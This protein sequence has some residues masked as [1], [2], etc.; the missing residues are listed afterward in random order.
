MNMQW[1]SRT[2]PLAALAAVAI[3]AAAMG[4]TPPADQQAASA[5]PVAAP[6]AATPAAD[7]TPGPDTGRKSAQ[8]EIIVTGS[9][10]RRKDL[11]TP[12]PV[13]VISRDQ[14]TSSGV[15]SI[16]A[17]LQQLP[18]QG[19]AL[20]TNVNNGG[21]GETQINLRNLGS[22][23]TLVLVDGKRFVNGGVG[24]GTAVDL[25]SIP[26]AAVE[27]IEILKDGGSAVY[28]SD[29]IAGVVNIITR[30][31]MN[32]VE[33]SGYTGVSGHGDANVY[34]ANVLAGAQGD[35]GSFMVG[36]GYFKQD[37]FFASQRGWA[38]NAL[39]WD[40]PT[41]TAAPSGS[42][43]LPR[44]RVNALDPNTCQGKTAT[45]FNLFN[46]FGAGKRNF[47]F[48]PTHVKVGALYS[49]DGWRVRDPA[50]DFYNYQAVN[51]LLTPSERIS[52]F[53]NGE[54]RIA[55]FA[56]T[57]LQASYVSRTSTTLVA[58]EPFVTTGNPQLV[59]D[60]KN[61]YNPFGVPLT[62]IQRPR[63]H[64]RNALKC[65]PIHILINLR[66]TVLAEMERQGHATGVGRRVAFQM[67]LAGS[68]G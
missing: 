44:V 42:G 64:N 54:F 49:P 13:T 24:A 11:T 61:P 25:N 55:D 20:N 10:V 27:R 66:S 39:S 6:A 21:D 50:V 33:L 15:A 59:I 2:L 58:P 5:P 7:A 60:A 65:L 1:K 36:A 9:R 29:A 34:D 22:Q 56:R 14:I 12:A 40:F 16:G 45:C 57:Y 43:T 17:F 67:F 26:T 63:L 51:Y 68:D 23:R 41:G 46:T 37:S 18:E 28:G 3:S 53:G 31:R 32:G 4:Q 47:I 8:E 52:L 38:A 19:G 62:S 48:D 30:K 35:Q